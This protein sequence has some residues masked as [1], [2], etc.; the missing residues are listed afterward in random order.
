[1]LTTTDTSLKKLEREIEFLQ[2]LQERLGVTIKSQDKHENS[3]KQKKGDLAGQATLKRAMSGDPEHVRKVYEFLPN[4]ISISSPWEEKHI[5]IPVACL[6]V[7]YPQKIEEVKDSKKYNFGRSCYDLATEIKKTGES[8]GTERR[9]RALL[10]TSLADIRS[11]LT[12]LVRQMKSK[13]VPISINY[14]QL[15]ADLRQWEHPNQHVQDRWARTYWGAAPSSI[16]DSIEESIE[17]TE[18]DN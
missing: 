11:P 10:D 6:F 12:N 3:D 4:K 1:M 14:P 17:P 15:L 8:K 9:F 7:F 16:E 18:I 5:W 2:L 13:K